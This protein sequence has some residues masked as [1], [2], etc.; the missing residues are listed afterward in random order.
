LLC[1][2]VLLTV[3]PFI[4]FYLLIVGFSVLMALLAKSGGVGIGALS[5]LV[6]LIGLAGI[7]GSAV[8]F[9]YAICRYALAVTASTLEKLPARAALIRTKFLTY[10]RKWSILGIL[11][12]TWLLSIVL[13]Y[14]LQLPALLASSAVVMSARTHLS[15]AATIWIYIA[16]F[17]GETLAGP[18]ITIALVLVYYDQR[19]RKEAFD[20]QLMMEAVGEQAQMPSAATQSTGLAL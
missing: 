17:L 12:L 2:V 15:I 9:I 3:G 5:V 14:V 1:L 19:V 13:T 10:G 6:V 7:L 18:I 4:F 20:L 8:W 11:I 16:G